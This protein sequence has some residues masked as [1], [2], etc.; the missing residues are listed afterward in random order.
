MAGIFS[1]SSFRTLGTAA[2]PQNLLTIENIDA[3]KL[4]TIRRLTVQ[5]DAT[6]VLVSV[7]PQVKASRATAVPTGGT[8]LAKAQ[9]D[10]GNAS[11][12][13]SIVRGG[14][15][16]DGGVATAITSTAGTTIWQQYTMRMHTVVGQV[17]GV[18][19]NVLPSLVDTQN[20]ILRQ[21]QALLVQIVASA[22][23][24]NPATNHWFCNIVWEE[25]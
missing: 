1:A 2:T 3:T 12:A 5:M 25:D 8:V 6:A 21:N 22:G 9:F 16:S 14:T 13:N 19:S 23:A 4:I 7:M 20:L 18:D 24:S 15:A 11:N 10:T 17:L